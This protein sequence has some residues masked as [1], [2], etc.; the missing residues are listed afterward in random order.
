MPPPS[1]SRYETMTPDCMNLLPEGRRRAFRQVYFVRLGTVTLLILCAVL[2]MHA[3]FLLPSYLLLGVQVREREAELAHLATTQAQ[4]GAEEIAARVTALGTEAAYLGTL[5]ETP[6]AS[7]DVMR[8]IAL[9][10]EGVTLAGFSY[11]P[12]DAG[13]ARLMVHGTAATRDA[14]RR[15]EERVRAAPFVR[16]AEL[17]ISAY[18]K[19]RD[20]AFTLT[21]TLAP[22]L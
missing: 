13:S 5:A 3:V 9:P 19:E 2:A 16:A 1:A 4:G 6:K 20:I 22:S 10:R 11:A 12:D 21:L 14:L 8:V 17:P 18:A 15:Y 7:T